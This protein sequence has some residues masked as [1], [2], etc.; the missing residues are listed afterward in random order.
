MRS[1]NEY[2]RLA[3]DL[4]A[5]SRASGNHPFGALWLGR[6]V[7]CFFH[8]ATP[9]HGSRRRPR[10]VKRGARGRAAIRPCFSR[11][12][13]VGDLGRAA[14]VPGPNTGPASEL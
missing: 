10:R 3:M 1:D 5:A 13:H 8:R 11:A 7:R 9:M 4:A 6:K 2:L 12:M 14:C